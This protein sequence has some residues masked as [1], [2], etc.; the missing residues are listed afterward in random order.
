MVA[1]LKVAE[2]SLGILLRHREYVIVM[3]DGLDL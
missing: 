1:M 2:R 3:E